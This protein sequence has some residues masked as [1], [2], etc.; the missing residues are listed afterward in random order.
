MFSLRYSRESAL[1]MIGT[2]G[3]EKLLKSCITFIGVGATGS[4][5]ADLFA[6]NG[7]G[8]IRVSDPDTVDISNLHRQ[9]LYSEG[10]TG[11]NKAEAAEKRINQ[12]NGKIRVKAYG[13]YVDSSNIEEVASGSSLIIDG[14]DNMKSR[15]PINSY[16]A[17]SG[18]PWIFT[19]ASGS[20]GQVKIIV[21]G[22]TACLDCLGIDYGIQDIRCED[23]GVLASAPYMVG[24][25]A[26]TLGIR[27]LLGHQIE[28][29]VYNIDVPAMEIMKV[30]T[31]RNKACK[32]CGGSGI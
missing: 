27:Y 5:S 24:S 2:A 32:T 26:W 14:T 29:A 12:I 1:A 21:P 18:I 4:A 11:I 23:V 31:S 9:S 28:D 13:L 15:N 10:D 16:S 25:I 22:K 17:R 8:E 7:A 19:S 20:T 30:R 6:R 3:L